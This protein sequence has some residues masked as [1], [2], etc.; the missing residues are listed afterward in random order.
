MDVL[1]PP[2]HHV[3]RIEDLP[4]HPHTTPPQAAT[5]AHGNSDQPLPWQIIAPSPAA[6]SECNSR[7]ESTHKTTKR[8]KRR[9]RE[10]AFALVFSTDDDDDVNHVGMNGG[11]ELWGV[12]PLHAW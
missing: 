9:K 11:S 8:Q 1:H 2:S 12:V 6:W 7:P 3:L 10:A 4:R 5:S